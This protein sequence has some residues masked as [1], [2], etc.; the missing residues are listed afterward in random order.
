[1]DYSKNFYQIKSNEEIF[2]KVSLEK[3]TVGYYDLPF[4][5]TSEFKEYAK[6]VTQQDIVVVGIG[7]SSLG[8]YAIHKFLQHKENMKKLH[9]LESTDPLDLERRISKLDLNDTLFIIISKSGTTIETVSILKYLSS[10]TMLDK[11]NTIC[12]TESD[13]KLNTYAK[14]N[15][16]KTFE[17]PK[18]VGGRFSVFTA[19]GLVTMAIMGLDIDR[20]LF[21]CQTIYNDY[22]NRG[23]YYTSI[24]EKARFIVENK[25]RFNIN[26]VFS[27]SSLL[28]GFNKWYVQLWGESLG[29]ININ[30]TKQ[31]LTPIALTGPVDQ[32]SFLQLIMEGKRDKT[33]TFIKVADFE[34]ELTIPDVSLPGLEEL[35]YIN[36]IKFKNLINEQ[37]DATIEAIQNLKDI[38]CDIITIEAQDEYNIGKLMYSYELLTSIVGSFVQINTYDQPGVEAGKIILKDKLK[39][40]I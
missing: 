21:G 34:N 11:S 18:N 3:N 25:N 32:H 7:G 17:I 31:A 35:D 39:K 30:Q 28:E 40:K 6:T 24:M 9:F 38:P 1:M 36:N 29:K 10:I 33:I 13:S 26:V 20:I 4:Q 2:Y 19:V 8:T 27:Y 37:A 14:T 23:D 16:M 5:D 22:F 12:I 15:D